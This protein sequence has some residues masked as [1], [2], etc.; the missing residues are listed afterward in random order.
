MSVSGLMR[1][2]EAGAVPGFA[3]QAQ[4]GEAGEESRGEG[5]AEIKADTLGD[6][7]DADVDDGALIPSQTGQHGEEEPCVEL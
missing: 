4:Q 2:N 6:F 1:G 5:N 3:L 7:A